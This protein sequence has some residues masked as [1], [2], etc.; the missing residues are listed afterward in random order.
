LAE[1]VGGRTPALVT[2]GA[3]IYNRSTPA[4]AVLGVVLME[5]GDVAMMTRRMLLGIKQRAE[6]HVAPGPATP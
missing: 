6:T 2:R 1:L 3:A 5:L 4:M